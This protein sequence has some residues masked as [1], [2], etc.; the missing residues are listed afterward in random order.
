MIK[1]FTL[2]VM[3]EAGAGGTLGCLKGCDGQALIEEAS[4]WFNTLFQDTA[5]RRKMI[6]VTVTNIVERTV[7][8]SNPIYDASESPPVAKN[9]HT[10]TFAYDTADLPPGVTVLNKCDL[11]TDKLIACPDENGCCPF[12]DETMFSG[13]GTEEDPITLT[14]FES[15][16]EGGIQ[17][18][19]DQA[20]AFLALVKAALA[21][22]QF[23]SAVSGV[24][25]APG[26]TT[27]LKAIY[28]TNGLGNEELFWSDDDG[29]AWSTDGGLESALNNS[30]NGL[31]LIDGH[32]DVA[33]GRVEVESAIAFSRLVVCDTGSGA[34]ASVNFACTGPE[35]Q[36]PDLKAL[37]R[38][39]GYDPAFLIVGSSDG[40]SGG[41]SGGGGSGG[42]SGGTGAVISTFQFASLGQNTVTVPANAAKV[43]I[44]ALGAGGYNAVG[45]SVIAEFAISPGG[46]IEPGDSLLAA[47]GA[48]VI[49]NNTPP[50]P[51][52]ATGVF[53]GAY[54]RANALA[55][56]GGG[57]AQGRPSS[58]GLVEGYNGNA[59]DGS[60]GQSDMSGGPYIGVGDAIWGAGGYGYE[61]GS[62]GSGTSGKAGT[63]FIHSSGSLRTFQQEEGRF[64]SGDLP[65]VTGF[66]NFTGLEGRTQHGGYLKIVF[67]D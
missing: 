40:G 52:Y 5:G 23:Q 20:P 60:G 38:A 44:E 57:S 11:Y 41:G 3:G 39:L 25:A 49:N 18:K 58:S 56:A 66:T 31:P 62:T 15:D 4:Y 26:P 59:T 9:G 14:M 28:Y 21:P 17:L 24:I 16:G 51:N 48:S 7:S 37:I 12:F 33:S 27:V 13:A 35:G 2:D 47:V 1:T 50:N 65:P 46:L 8:G 63:S 54:T 55:V 6:Q 43:R 19:E 53:L 34:S 30:D 22:C 10:Y 64:V 29:L 42:G 36:D 61:G 45:A 67:Y 32:W